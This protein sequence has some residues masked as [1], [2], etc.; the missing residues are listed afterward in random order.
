MRKP[1]IAGNWKMYKTRDEV[2]AFTSAIYHKLP[3]LDLVD[4]VI[5][6]PALSTS[7]GESALTVACVPTGIKIGV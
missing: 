5:C 1:I 2:I 7:S 4:N 6:A 3:S